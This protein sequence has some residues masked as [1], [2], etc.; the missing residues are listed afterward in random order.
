MVSH[1]IIILALCCHVLFKCNLLKAPNFS[2]PPYL[3]SLI[4]ASPLAHG[5]KVSFISKCK[6]LHRELQFCLKTCLLRLAHPLPKQAPPGGEFFL[7]W[8][9]YHDVGL[10]L[11]CAFK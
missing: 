5:E 4:K 7:C 3:A 11:L 1:S 10:L 9:T 6:K 8:A 2:Q